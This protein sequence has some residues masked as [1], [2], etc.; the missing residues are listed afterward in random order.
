M[1]QSTIA[2]LT[3]NVCNMYNIDSGTALPQQT[4]IQAMY[5]NINILT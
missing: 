2:L 4:W 3:V 5:S 1:S